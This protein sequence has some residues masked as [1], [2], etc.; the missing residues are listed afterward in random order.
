MGSMDEIKNGGLK[1]PPLAIPPRPEV[2]NIL[3]EEK[4]NETPDLRR[5]ARAIM[6]DVGLSGAMLKT[7]NSPA[8]G[9]RRKVSSI[10]AALDLLG[11]NN[12][13]TL[14]TGL[15]LRHVGGDGTPGMDRFWDSAEKVAVAATYLA[16]RLRAIS[17]DQAYTYGLFHDCGIP[18]LIQ[19]YP[20]YKDLLAQA[21]QTVGQ[22]FT[23]VEDRVLGTHHAAV[24][25]FL[26][27]SWHLSEDLCQSVL[28]HHEIGVFES[29]PRISEGA[30]NLIGIGHMAEHV[31]HRLLRSGVDTEWEKFEM[32]ICR[33]FGLDEEECFTL[34]E[35][36]QNF[37]AS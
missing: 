19:R 4:E 16:G 14:A 9:L 36:T 3:I 8:F 2:V 15:I 35:D 31:H 22:I 32:S 33:H 13:A 21:N 18:L 1:I 20:E 5:V 17:K 34:L 11:M 6:T 26:A 29:A 23:V 10:A 37:L 27:R 28:L 12:V 7:V 24:G 25:Y 30:L